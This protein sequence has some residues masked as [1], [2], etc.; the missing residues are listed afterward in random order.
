MVRGIDSTG[1][2]EVH[3]ED[4][5]RSLSSVPKVSYS[6]LQVREA[7]RCLAGPSA[8]PGRISVATLGH[9]LGR[10]GPG[11]PEEKVHDYLAKMDRP[12]NSDTIDYAQFV[13]LMMVDT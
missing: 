9:A 2:G 1:T 6:E 12:P 8:P 7:F 4:L 3:F 11:M 10:F 5:V 13:H